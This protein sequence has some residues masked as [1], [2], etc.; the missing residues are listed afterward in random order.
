MNFNIADVIA[1]YA[2]IVS[3]GVLSLEVRRWFESAIRLSVTM[4][5]EAKMTDDPSDRT[6][7][8]VFVVNRGPT[9]TTVTHMTLHEYPSLWARLRGKASWNAIVPNPAPAGHPNI[10]QQVDPN[11]RWVGMAVYDDDLMERRKRGHLYVAIQATHSD[12]A[13]LKRVPRP[14]QVP[15]DAKAIE[16]P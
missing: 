14:V 10:P 6:Y 13:T 9:P 15:S 1:S 11:A 7:L 5:P 4:M 12:K 3:T 2:A 16:N 8:A